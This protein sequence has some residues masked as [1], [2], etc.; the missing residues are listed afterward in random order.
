MGTW[1]LSPWTTRDL[2]G[3]SIRTGNEKHH[4]SCRLSSKQGPGHHGMTPLSPPS[5]PVGLSG[6]PF[7]R[8]GSLTH[9][10]T[11]QILDCSV[12][13]WYLGSSR[14]WSLKETPSRGFQ[15]PTVQHLNQLLTKSP[16]LQGSKAVRNR[17]VGSPRV[18]VAAVSPG[19]R[20]R[21]APLRTLRFMCSDSH[22]ISWRSSR[23]W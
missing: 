21:T 8:G 3:T 13:L 12:L 2:Y 4:H 9:G 1:S 19:S 11:I 5:R 15:P 23:W 10:R 16:C 22:T 18:H 6:H 20:Q 14:G 17:A 7:S